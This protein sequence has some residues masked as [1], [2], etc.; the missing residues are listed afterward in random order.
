MIF[1]EKAI[2]DLDEEIRRL[3]FIREKVGPTV[4][5]A[6]GGAINALI[7]VRDGGKLTSSKIAGRVP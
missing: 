7:W 1:V 5:S 4:Q 3:E 2:S 6:V